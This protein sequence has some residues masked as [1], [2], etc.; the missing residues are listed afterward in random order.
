[1][2][3]KVFEIA[4]SAFYAG[5]KKTSI[6]WAWTS[7]NFEKGG[8]LIQRVLTK[9]QF[10][11]IENSGRLIHRAGLYTRIYGTR[12]LQL[13]RLEVILTPPPP[14]PPNFPFIPFD[15]QLVHDPLIS[16]EI[17]YWK[18]LYSQLQRSLMSPLKT[19]GKRPAR[20]HMILY[21]ACASFHN[22]YLLHASIALYQ[23]TFRM[24][25]SQHAMFIS[26]LE[27][28]KVTSTFFPEIKKLPAPNTP[29]FFSSKGGNKN[30]QDRVC[31]LCCVFI[32][33]GISFYNV[34]MQKD[35]SIQFIVFC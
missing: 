34:N 22:A 8:W 26:T 21:W 9:T 2:R 6:F 33:I 28:N 3:G 12:K 18:Q 24:T 19:K 29:A 7:L 13:Y 14:P 30:W 16:L 20:I 27:G 35:L 32:G 10:F 4:S 23:D 5:I 17:Y 15:K 31:L 25:T 1:M 11:G